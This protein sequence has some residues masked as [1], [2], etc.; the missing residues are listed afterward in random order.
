MVS[1][2]GTLGFSTRFSEPLT[3]ALCPK[4]AA[5][6]NAGSRSSFHSWRNSYTQFRSGALMLEKF[7]SIFLSLLADVRGEL[8]LTALGQDIKAFTGEA[9]AALDKLSKDNN[10]T[11]NRLLTIE[12]K[13]VAPRGGFA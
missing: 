9:K 4:R 12:Q 11:L 10:E 8:D 6:C 5:C 13:M 1:F 3:L 2:C 7:L